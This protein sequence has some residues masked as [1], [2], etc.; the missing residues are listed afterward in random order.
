VRKASWA[1]IEAD[2]EVVEAVQRGGRRAELQLRRRR[3][4]V[5]GGL[6]LQSRR[7]LECWQ[8]RR[9]GALAYSRLRARHSRHD[10]F[11]CPA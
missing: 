2:S 1:A 5:L 11:A 7:M 3:L 4:G 6:K 8:R 9:V 10:L